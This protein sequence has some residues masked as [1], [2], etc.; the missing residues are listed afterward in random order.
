MEKKSSIVV[1]DIYLKFFFTT[2]GVVL[3]KV[4]LNNK[5]LKTMSAT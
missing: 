5:N 3:I 1:R 4:K 2:F